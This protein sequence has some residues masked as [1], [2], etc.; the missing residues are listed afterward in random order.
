M[1]TEFPSLVDFAYAFA[2]PH[3]MTV[4]RPDSGDKTLLDL[5]PGSL[6]LAWTYESPKRFPLGAFMTP[7]TSWE[8]RL[9]PSLDGHPFA[10]S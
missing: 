4:A 2:T 1:A 10:H 9:T 5:Q 7:T 3:R 8:L 6:R